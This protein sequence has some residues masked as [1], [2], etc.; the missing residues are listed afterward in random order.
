MD[1]KRGILIGADRLG[2]EWAAARGVRVERHP[3]DFGTWGKGAGPMQNKQM[4]EAGAH[5]CI[6]APGGAGTDSMT[7][8]AER[9][10]IPVWRPFG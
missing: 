2:D 10:G 1:P 4:A 9:G 7:K 6:A 5:G 3:A 8:Q